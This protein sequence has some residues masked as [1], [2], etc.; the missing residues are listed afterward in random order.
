[1]PKRWTDEKI[2]KWLTLEPDPDAIVE[3]LEVRGIVDTS[4]RPYRHYLDGWIRLLRITPREAL[5]EEE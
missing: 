5:L 3:R 4:R 1:M 2:Q